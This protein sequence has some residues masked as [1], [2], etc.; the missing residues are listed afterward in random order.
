MQ[1]CRPWEKE[2]QREHEVLALQRQLKTS[3]ALTNQLAADTERQQAEFERMQKIL[4]DSQKRAQARVD[5]A[6][7][8]QSSKAFLSSKT[9]CW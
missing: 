8:Q 3:R 6:A 1:G 5:A 7:Q 2:Q 9:F 4:E